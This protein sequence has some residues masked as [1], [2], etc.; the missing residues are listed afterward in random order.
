MTGF[1]F[2]GCF[3]YLVQVLSCVLVRLV[4][5][6]SEIINM[7][8]ALLH[9]SVDWFGLIKYSFANFGY[10]DTVDENAS[11]RITEDNETQKLVTE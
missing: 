11:S 8:S 5:Y 3:S 9:L 10:Q 6:I 7:N 4:S 1:S 2:S